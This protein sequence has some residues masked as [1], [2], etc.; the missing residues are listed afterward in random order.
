[1]VRMVVFQIHSIIREIATC[2][3][4][5]QASVIRYLLIPDNI[6]VEPRD[7]IEVRLYYK[8]NPVSSTKILEVPEFG[9]M[10]I[11]DLVNIKGEQR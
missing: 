11:V 9:T 8:G 4:W 7:R 3:L 1:M 2:C 5:G 10:K 6:G